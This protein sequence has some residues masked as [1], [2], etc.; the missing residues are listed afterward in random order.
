MKPKRRFIEQAL[1][2]LVKEPEDGM[3]VVFH[4]AGSLHLDGL[5]CYQTA[6]FPT[7]VIRAANDD[8]VLD[9]LSPFIAGFLMKDADLNRAIRVE[10]RKICR[11]LGRCEEA[12]P[13]HLFFSSPNV[14][15]AFTRHA[16][17]L[18]ELTAQVPFVDGDKMVK[19]SRPVSIIRPRLSGPLE[20]RHIQQCVE[21]AL[22]HRVGLTVVGGGHSGH[23]LWPNVVSIDMGAFDQIHILAGGRE[24]DESG[25]D[26]GPLVVTEAGCKTG[27]VVRK[28]LTAGLTVPLGARPSVGAGL[29]LQGGIGHLARLH[30]LTC[31]AIVG[32]VVVSVDSGQV[33]CVGRA[34][35]QH[36]PVSA[37]RPDN[38][39]DLLWAIKGAGTNFGIVVSVT[40]K[41][42]AAPT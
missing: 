32:A 16:T 4:R 25:S 12:S 28:T 9:C 40:L 34:P 39:A 22:R 29:W 15:V 24:H 14:M 1:E 7:G 8:E 38:E 26:A 33:L 21:W 31:D 37:V 2:M 18:Q 23:C 41:A 30:G 19:T 20:V 42:F 3:V 27:D 10:W 36:C 6:S 11:A 13:G 5:V 35:S 17:T